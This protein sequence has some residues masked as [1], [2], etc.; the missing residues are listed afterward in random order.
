MHPVPIIH[1]PHAY[2]YQTFCSFPIPPYPKVPMSPPHTTVASKPQIAKKKTQSGREGKLQKLY[3]PGSRIQVTRAMGG[4]MKTF[5]ATVCEHKQLPCGNMESTLK[6]GEEVVSNPSHLVDIPESVA[7]ARSLS[8]CDNS[9]ATQEPYKDLE[10]GKDSHRLKIEDE[11]ARKLVER[12][13]REWKEMMEGRER[14][15]NA[16]RIEE[17]RRRIELQR[18]RE[19]EDAAWRALE[20]TRDSTVEVRTVDEYEMDDVVL[21]GRDNIDDFD[22]E[23]KRMLWEAKEGLDA[24]VQC[25]RFIRECKEAN[26]FDSC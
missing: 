8:S 16:A 10:S 4:L 11:N 23:D 13:R 21:Y 19:R 22:P 17:S 9:L 2:H 5:W 25:D 1:F 18:E 15:E 7:R 26:A 6:L 20:A 24:A 12:R 14:R 3:P